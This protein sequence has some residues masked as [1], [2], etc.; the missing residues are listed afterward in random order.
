MRTALSV[1]VAGAIGLVPGVFIATPALA[2]AGDYSIAAGSG[3]EGGTVSLRIT[4]AGKATANDPALPAEKLTWSTIADDT[5]QANQATPGTD[6]T[7]V[8]NAAV[9]FPVWDSTSPQVKTITV[10]TKQ[11]TVDEADKTFKASIVAVVAASDNTTPTAAAIS[12]ANAVGTIIDDDS[13]TYTLI[14]TPAATVREDV[15]SVKVRATIPTAT[16]GDVTIP[17]KTEDDTAKAGQ[18]YDEFDADLTITEGATYGE[19][20]IDLI[21]DDLDEDDQQSFWVRGLAGTNVSG[22]QSTRINILDDEA[23]SKITLDA[24]VGAASEGNPLVFPVTLDPKSERAVSASWSTGTAK[25]ATGHGVAAAGTD[26]TAVTN[27]TVAFDADSA[28]PKAPISVSTLT[29]SIDEADEDLAVTVSNATNATIVSPNTRNGTITDA[30]TT[31]GPQVELVPG[32]VME[33]GVGTPRSRTF[34][35]RL[36][37]ASGQEQKVQYEVSSGISGTATADEDFTAVA[38]GARTILTFAPGETEKTFTVDVIGDDIDEGDGETFA[39]TLTDAHISRLQAGKALGENTITIKDDDDKPTFRLTNKA[40][41]IP[42]G[43]GPSAALLEVRLSNPSAEDIDWVVEPAT[44]PGTAVEG[45]A[46]AGS[47]DYTVLGP[48]MGAGTIA[49]GDTTG[50]VLGIINGDRVF[51]ADE[52]ARWTVGLDDAETDATGVTET[53]I[54][55]I[56]NDDMPPELVVDNATGEE[57]KTIALTGTTAGVAQGETLL[58]VSLAGAANGGHQAA[59]ATDFAPQSFVVKIPAGTPAGATIPI[60]DVQITE[61]ELKESSETIR[62]SGTGFSG[63]GSVKDGWITIAASDGGEPGQPGE[64]GEPG[65]PEPGAPTVSTPSASLNGGGTATIT[66]KA[67]ANARVELWGVPFGSD[68]EPK[69]LKATTANASGQY[70]LTHWIGQGYI[71]HT[72][73][74]DL[75]SKEIAVRVKQNPVFT[76]TSPSKG[77]FTVTVTGNPKAAGQDIMVQS[78]VSGAWKTVYKGKTG[79]NGVYTRTVKL[80]SG[81]ALT[82][83]GFVAGDTGMGLLGNYS[84]AKKVT[85]K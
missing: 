72:R 7:A 44:D 19:I 80:D 6:F 76:L 16:V 18:D 83:R 46:G 15:A 1:A 10:A 28:T 48:V 62:V 36:T 35:A 9:S 22:T 68:E 2:A 73:V 14:A 25:P 65:E 37:K 4:R 51:E 39:I 26:F 75:K 12:P 11:N 49:A 17:I 55:T 29:D 3:T 81:K 74:G 84:T 53:G 79:S 43:D 31:P 30:G 58:N 70:S 45:G 64:P 71:F 32:D 13:P 24:P 57:G 8:V 47:N 59:S 77:S 5:P 67:A 34:T 82:M 52:T 78:Y 20:T 61:D 50:Y 42:E 60:G 85:V 66:G 69:R 41:T 56:K 27:G 23:T 21:D 63:T 33:G 38:P 40:M 54:L